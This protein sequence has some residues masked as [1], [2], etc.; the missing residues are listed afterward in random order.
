MECHKERRMCFVI[1][2][3]IVASW[4]NPNLDLL[5]TFAI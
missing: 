3:D 4:H 2:K 5:P 1:V